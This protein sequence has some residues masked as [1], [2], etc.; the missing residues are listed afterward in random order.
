MGLL[1]LVF[2]SDFV[3]DDLHNFDD[4]GQQ[5]LLGI[6]NHTVPLARRGHLQGSDHFRSHDHQS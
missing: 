5:H 6:L 3:N 1:L 2:G 4:N